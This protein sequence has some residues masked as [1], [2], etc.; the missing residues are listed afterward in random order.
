MEYKSEAEQILLAGDY[1]KNGP[2]LEKTK[3]M[4]FQDLGLYIRNVPL[5]RASDSMLSHLVMLIRRDEATNVCRGI[6]YKIILAAYMFSLHPSKVFEKVGPSEQSLIDAS[7]PMLECFHRTAVGMA[8]GR[9][10]D[11]LK[12]DPLAAQ[13][14]SALLSDYFLKFTTWRQADERRLVAMLTQ[15]LD[16]NKDATDKLDP[17]MDDFES[18]RSAL[19]EK[20]VV[21]RARL[22]SVAGEKGLQDYLRRRAAGITPSGI[23]MLHS[24]GLTN[25]QLAYELL[26]DENF[27]IDMPSQDGRRD[28]LVATK[29]RDQY[30]D[31]DFAN[32]LEQ[33]EKS[34]P[35]YDTVL[36]ALSMLESTL[37]CVSVG[38]EMGH[39]VNAVMRK[40][41]FQLRTSD[42]VECL[43]LFEELAQLM[44]GLCEAQGLQ[45]AGEEVRAKW[46]GVQSNTKAGI[47]CEALELIVYLVRCV[48]ANVANAKLD[49]IVP[50]VTQHGFMYMQ[51]HFESKR[52]AGIVTLEKTTEWLDTVVARLLTSDASDRLRG[53]VSPAQLASGEEPVYESVFMYA[54]LELLLDASVAIPDTLALDDLR[55]RSLRDHFHTDVL[56]L[57]YMQTACDHLATF[58]TL[59]AHDRVS[60]A[61]GVQRVLVQSPPKPCLPLKCI[62]R[63]VAAVPSAL[64]SGL[65]ALLQQKLGGDNYAAAET[66]IM[67]HWA[68]VLVEEGR[69]LAGVEA[70]LPEYVA[71]LVRASRPHIKTMAKMLDVNMKIHTKHYHTIIKEAAAKAPTTRAVGR[72]TVRPSALLEWISVGISRLVTSA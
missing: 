51:K 56:S 42:C 25:E 11:S 8:E 19:M 23:R 3:S 30:T 12:H 49:K 7:I 66:K 59:D 28:R 20:D 68:S 63:V 37:V 33:L 36:N 67:M 17:A 47:I 2:S 71:P 6:N 52:S 21:L 34:P 32:V 41:R 18:T 31:M 38:K 10:W 13:P 58:T 55:I 27:R 60:I 39:R 29:I 9:T 14:L 16:A 70:D 35:V 46:V 48:Q 45:A 44:K 26:L 53:L 54:V 40:F 69:G 50:V 5:L 15:A 1:L 24:G 62:E 22:V 65:E 4:S 72:L 64:Q 43:A 61:L 57:V